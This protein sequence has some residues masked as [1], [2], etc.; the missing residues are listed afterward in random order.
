MFKIPYFT[1]RFRIIEYDTEES[2]AEKAY[3]ELE[4][5]KKQK[6]KLRKKADEIKAEEESK[7]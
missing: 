6:R 2:E 4:R 1:K 5:V 7:I 3:E